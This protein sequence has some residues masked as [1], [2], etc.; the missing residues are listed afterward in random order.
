MQ[1]WGRQAENLWADQKLSQNLMFRSRQ[2]FFFSWK[3][4][5]SLLQPSVDWM[6]LAHIIRNNLLH[7]KA[8]GHRCSSLRNTR[9]A[10]PA[11]EVARVTGDFT[12][13]PRREDE[14]WLTCLPRL[15]NFPT[16]FSLTIFISFCTL[17]FFSPPFSFTSSLLAPVKC[18]FES[19]RLCAPRNR[20]FVSHAAASLSSASVLSSANSWFLSFCCLPHF[21]FRFFNVW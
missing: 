9:T 3:S 15:S 20:A 1:L 8:T 4:H 7:W 18:G 10:P 14:M 2:N 5:C 6:R 16:T 17:I 13:R 19:I 12:P 11:A 21:Y